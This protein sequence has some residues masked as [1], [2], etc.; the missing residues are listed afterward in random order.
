MYKLEY[1]NK[2]KKELDKLKKNKKFPAKTLKN[3]IDK[4]TKQEKLKPSFKNHQFQGKWKN[5][6]DC[7]IKTDL[8]LI[9]K[10]NKKRKIIILARIGSHSNLF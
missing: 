5:F 10:I 2:F 7:H 8:I 9:Y 3:I 1:T 4:I 6:Y